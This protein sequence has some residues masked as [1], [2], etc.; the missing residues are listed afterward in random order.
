[1]E[2]ALADNAGD[3]GDE[4]SMPGWHPLQYS[5]LVTLYGKRSLAGYSSWGVIESDRS[6]VTLH[7]YT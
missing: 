5:C 2:K 6:E 4:G 3:I 1:M 7:K